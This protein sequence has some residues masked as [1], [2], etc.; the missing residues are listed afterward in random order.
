[1][2][3]G[4]TAACPL[5]K[6]E[7]TFYLQEDGSGDVVA[8]GSGSLNTAALTAVSDTFHIPM[9][10][11]AGADLG[12]GVPGSE[13]IGFVGITGPSIFGTGGATGAFSSGDF[14]GITGLDNEIFLPKGYVSGT[15]L[16][17]AA[18]FQF[19]SFATLG[20]TLGTYTWTWGTGP[21]ADSLTVTADADVP[22]PASLSLLL[23]GGLALL[24]RRP[25]LGRQR[26][27]AS[28][29]VSGK[30]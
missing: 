1:M 6:A 7:F 8:T 21:T 23:F 10:I 11:P 3:W 18:E 17:D 16:S 13:V 30:A 9:I 28:L 14:V 15:P 26:R 12:I 22:E 5:A 29:R 19:E 20:I 2:L 4:L 25:S 27:I 24:H